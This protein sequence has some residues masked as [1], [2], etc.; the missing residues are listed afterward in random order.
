MR[1]ALAQKVRVA[2]L[3][4]VERTG[5][6]SSSW[7]MAPWAARDCT[8]QVAFIL[9]ALD[10]RS[11]LIDAVGSGA[12]TPN[13]G[14]ELLL[15]LDDDPVPL[16]QHRAKAWEDVCAALTE[17]VPNWAS[18]GSAGDSGTELAIAAIRA[19]AA[20]ASSSDPFS[21]SVP[22]LVGFD[23]TK[24]VGWLK[25]RRDAMPPTADFCFAISY[26]P[27]EGAGRNSGPYRLHAVSIVSDESYIQGLR[28][29]GLLPAERGGLAPAQEPKYTVN[30]QSI[31]NRASG[32]AIPDDEPVFI[33]R[34][35]DVHA[36]STLRFYSNVLPRGTA[37][38]LA[39]M[40]RVIDFDT[41]ATANPER[42]REPDTADPAAADPAP[43]Q[44]HPIDLCAELRRAVGLFD[45]AMPKSPKE[46][47]DEAIARVRALAK[48]TVV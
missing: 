3:Q 45:G 6:N 2:L 33:F 44:P 48:R 10:D 15:A 40:N 20:A 28:K 35:R 22:I 31:V 29:D 19:L 42:M 21:I 9:A 25:L 11:A 34:A 26:E 5:P 30:G 41:W 1:P 14:R 38:W 46:A 16:V 17:V 8:E 4:L 27:Q 18:Q 23:A 12:L 7:C 32:E 37:H 47:W 13:R 43:F 24:P 36:R 39:V